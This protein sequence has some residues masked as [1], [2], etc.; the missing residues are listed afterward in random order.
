M[1]RY[2]IASSASSLICELLMGILH[3][4][5]L[6]PYPL[7]LAAG[8]AFK[9][10]NPSTTAFHV[11]V[12]FIFVSAFTMLYCNAAM[13]AF[14]FLQAVGSTRIRYISAILKLNHR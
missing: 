14:R 11:Y 12:N 2:I 6:T 4:I 9:L 1:F 3:P 7:M 10:V 13:F 5:P 8:G